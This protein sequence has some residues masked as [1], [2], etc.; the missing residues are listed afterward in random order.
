MDKLMESLI[1]T[2]GVSSKEIYMR[3]VIK[4]EIEDIKIN[5]NINIE[6]LEDVIGNLIVKLGKGSERIMICTHMDNTGVMAVMIENNGF[7]RVSPIGKLKPESLVR[8]FVKFENGTIGRID[9]SKANPSRDDLFIDLGISNKEVASK[10]IKEGDLGEVTGQGFISHNRIVAPNLHSKLAC[11]ALLKVI[12]RFKNIQ[13]LNKEFY[14]VFTSQMESGF[15]GARAAASEIKPSIAIAL[16]SI[17]A[18]DYIGG[19]YTLKLEMGPAVC[20]YDKSLIIHDDI[21]KLI[22]D[23]ADNLNINLQY[24]IGD[25]K[26]EGGLIHKEVGGIKTG[27]I[28]IPCRYM[29]TSGEMMSFKDINGTI[30]L[31]YGIIK[32]L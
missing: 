28:Q 3:N 12:R 32:K 17:E 30:D 9:A 5:D 23:T 31:I 19:S 24:I 26:N 4:E 1:K 22:Q 14:F 29:Y 6:V 15:R 20:I 2:F 13:S 7:I 25:N 10:R 27:V 11:Y 8:S 16:D 18:G 21:K